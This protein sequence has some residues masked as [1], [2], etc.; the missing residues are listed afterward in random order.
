MYIA[1]SSGIA[2]G[3]GCA[4]ASV[5]WAEAGP[6]GAS[7]AAPPPHAASTRLVI[8]NT[9]NNERT[10]L[11]ISI[12]SPVFNTRKSYQPVFKVKRRTG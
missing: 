12:F 1:I 5:G 6:A 2:A 3:S 10:V 9:N 8:T 11:V 4:G 7:V